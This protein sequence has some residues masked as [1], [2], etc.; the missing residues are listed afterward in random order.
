LA[1]LVPVDVNNDRVTDFVYAG[2]LKGN[3]WK[4]DLRGTNN[5][6][7]DVGYKTA[8]VA[9]PLYTAVDLDGNPQP[10]TSRPTV[11]DHPQGGYMIYFGTGKYF[12][13]SDAVLPATPQIQDFYGIRDNGASFTG[14]D[15]LLS[16]SIEFQGTATT[17]NGSISTNQIR[18]LTNNSA[19]SPPTYGWHLSLYPPSKART[20]E[21]VVSQ[22]VLRNGRIIFATIIP[23]ESVCG[24]GGS[25]FLME[26]DA[27]TGGRI[28]DPVLD[29]NGDGKVDLLDLAL[30]EGDY[31]P[32]SGIGGPEMIKTPSIIGAG[33]L[34]YKYTSGTSGTIGVITETGGGS[35]VSGRQS[36]RQLQ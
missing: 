18:I 30:F 33:E 5:S 8:G 27:D 1:T 15:K 31:Y 26:L 22:A 13:N 16:Q 25:S 21:R 6:Q 35:D 34:E 7:W 12:E 10:I 14:R 2:D 3:L 9:T 23:S 36:W 29:I 20:G 4:F 24:F 28:G 32:V 17:K 19:G 11:G